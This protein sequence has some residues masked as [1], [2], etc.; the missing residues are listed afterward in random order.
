MENWTFL[1]NHQ[2]KFHDIGV[3][4]KVFLWSRFD[5]LDVFIDF[6]VLG[7]FWGLEIFLPLKMAENE[8]F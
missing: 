2:C 4:I 7:I 5:C 1:E 6:L 8:L 3:I